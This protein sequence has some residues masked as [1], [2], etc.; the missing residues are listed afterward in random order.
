MNHND[1]VRAV[2]ARLVDEWSWEKVTNDKVINRLIYL[3]GRKVYRKDMKISQITKPGVKFK[4]KIGYR[5]WSTN[6]DPLDQARFTVSARVSK[7]DRKGTRLAWVSD[8]EG[9]QYFRV[10][11][12][13]PKKSEVIPLAE[14][15]PDP[16]NITDFQLAAIDMIYPEVYSILPRL[17]EGMDVI[18]NELRER[19][20]LRWT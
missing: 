10:I 20:G 7:K 17:E 14:L 11:D 18:H 19:F 16:K 2:V 6:K 5:G 12:Y 3:E 15:F 13:N 8:F 1:K 4:F 9:N